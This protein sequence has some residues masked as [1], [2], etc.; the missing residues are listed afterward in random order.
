MYICSRGSHWLRARGVQAPGPGPLEGEGKAR[1]G[2]PRLPQGAM[3]YIRVEYDI[4]RTATAIEATDMPGEFAQMLRE[5]R[6]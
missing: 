3:A 4:E 1:W 5:G 2:R 6:G